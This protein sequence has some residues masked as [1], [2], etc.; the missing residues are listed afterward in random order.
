LAPYPLGARWRK[1][2]SH[3]RNG[4]PYFVYADTQ[5]CKCLYVGVEAAYQRYQKLLVERKIAA[6]RRMTAEMNMDA[7]MDWDMWGPWDPWY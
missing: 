7:A 5:V 3:Q 1:I 6:D 4:K 2:I